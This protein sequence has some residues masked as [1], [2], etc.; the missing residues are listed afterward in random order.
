MRSSREWG[1]GLRAKRT[2]SVEMLQKSLEKKKYRDAVDIFGKKKKKKNRDAVDIV[3]VP[4]PQEIT[5][6]YHSGGILLPYNFEKL[7]LL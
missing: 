2:R 5:F 6:R 7:Q 4:G 1:W 3:H